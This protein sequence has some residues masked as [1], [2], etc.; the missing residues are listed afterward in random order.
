M[1]EEVTRRRST[2]L[3]RAHMCGSPLGAVLAATTCSKQVLE[4]STQEVMEE[5]LHDVL[6][7]DDPVQSHG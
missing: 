1:A 2:T 5:W 3:A 6:V 7:L 4:C